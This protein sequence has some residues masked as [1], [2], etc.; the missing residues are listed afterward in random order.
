MD[1]RTEIQDEREYVVLVEGV[2]NVEGPN[3]GQISSTNNNNYYRKEMK[4]SSQFKLSNECVYFITANSHSRRE[5]AQ[6]RR[7]VTGH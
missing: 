2:T 5:L 7:Y 3:K 4:R 1:A 6:L